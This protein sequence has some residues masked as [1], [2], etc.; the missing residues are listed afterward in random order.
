MSAAEVAQA[1]QE[2]AGLA[3]AL[4]APVVLTSPSDWDEWGP[5]GPPYPDSVDDGVDTDMAR[6]RRLPTASARRTGS[7]GATTRA[8]CREAPRRLRLVPLPL[9]DEQF[10]VT[11]FAF[12][13]F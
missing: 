7:A 11:Y 12:V 5:E 10:D 13:G 3:A 9:S 6:S 1:Q 2:L 4:T 8:P